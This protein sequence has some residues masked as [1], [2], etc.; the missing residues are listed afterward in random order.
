MEQTILKSGSS[1]D[2]SILETRLNKSKHFF[3]NSDV[4]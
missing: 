1:S 4:I 3:Q 2:F